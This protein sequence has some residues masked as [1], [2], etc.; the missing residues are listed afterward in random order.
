[1]IELR[2]RTIGAARTRC[3]TL[4]LTAAIG[5]V[6][7]ADAALTKIADKVRIDDACWRDD[8]NAIVLVIGEETKA[9][10]IGLTVQTTGLKEEWAIGTIL[11]RRKR[12]RDRHV[13]HEYA[14][15]T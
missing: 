14:V 11:D 5:T 7:K 1:M 10:T 8:A 15:P 9:W 4:D 13:H 3:H 2:H 6:D 12:P